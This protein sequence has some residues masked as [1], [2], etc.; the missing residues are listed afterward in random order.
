M[1]TNTQLTEFIN[2]NQKLIYS[3]ICKYKGLYDMDDLYQVALYG[4]CK[5]SGNYNSNLGIKFTTYAYKCMLGEVLNYVCTNR[6]VK[7]NKDIICLNKK[8]ENARLILSQKL[9]KEPSTSELALFLEMDESIISNVIL[10]NQSID[11]LDR[12][13][14]E[15]GKTLTVLDTIKNS[16]ASCSVDDIMLK[17]EIKKLSDFE[18]RIIYGRYFEDKTQ[19]EISSEL[20]VNQ[21]YVSRSEKKILKKMKDNMAYLNT[22]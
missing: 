5:Y 7:V 11:S 2:D 1:I 3:I 13:I 6:M 9:M 12:I 21:V 22:P 18:R 17:E 4:L 19:A 16:K 10:Y 15:D 14:K 20:G 8:I